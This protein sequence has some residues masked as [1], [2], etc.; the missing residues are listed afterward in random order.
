MRYFIILI[1]ILL[2]SHYVESQEYKPFNLDSGE[3]Y[4]VYSTK[5]GMFGGNHGTHYAT[6]SVKFFCSGDTVLNDVKFKKLLYSGYTSSQIVE[7]TFIS[8][9]YG[10]IR[11]DTLQKRVYFISAKYNSS[12]VLYDFDLSTGDSI[13]VSCELD[14][15]DAVS[16]IDSVLYCNQYHKR[17]STPSGY[18]II[19]GI[20]SKDGFIPA[21]CS[22]N[23][24]RIFCY[25]ESGNDLCN[26]CGFLTST[27]LFN[28]AS[29]TIFPNPT[30]GKVQIFSNLQI[31]YIELL[32]INGRLVDLITD[33]FKFIELKEKGFYL[34]RIHTGSEVF[35]RKIIKE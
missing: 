8:G 23:Y 27:D 18:F 34:L 31:R 33:D 4:C 14:D 6:D 16:Q 9:Y 12:Y 11:N 3:W 25:R 24:G 5:G 2:I 10:A 30:K 20:G 17:Y 19:E 35:T 28:Q 7:R 26:D 21:E 32:D 13:Q 29:L 22:P 1:L 15:K